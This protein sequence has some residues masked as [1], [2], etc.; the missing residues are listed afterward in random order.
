MPETTRH[1]DLWRLAAA[2]DVVPRYQGHD[3][4][5]HEASD[6]TVVRVLAALGVDASSPERVE[7]AL[8]HVE[9]I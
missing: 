2:Y 6:E 9:N 5:E 1:E 3:G 8:A 4:D 7:L